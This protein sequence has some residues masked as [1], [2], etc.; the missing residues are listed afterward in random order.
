VVQAGR[1]RLVVADHADDP[2]Q[3]VDLHLQERMLKA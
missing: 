1:H 2:G 3:G